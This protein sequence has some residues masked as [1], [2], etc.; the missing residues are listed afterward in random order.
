MALGSREAAEA[1]EGVLYHQYPH[2]GIPDFGCLDSQL[3]N[4]FRRAEAVV[5]AARQL[6]RRGFA[7]DVSVVHS[8]WGEALHLQKVW[9]DCRWIAYPEIYGS[10]ACLGYGFCRPL[11]QLSPQ[12]AQRIDRQ[13][14]LATAALTTYEAAVVPTQFQRGTFPPRLQP[15]LR[16]IHEGVALEKIPTGPAQPLT[17][18]DG[19]VLRRKTPLVTYTSRALEPLRGAD[20]F[21]KALPPLLHAHPT[22]QVVLVG[23][24]GSAYGSEA[25]GQEDAMAMRLQ[26]LLASPL[27][28]RIHWVERLPH[29]DLLALFRLSRAHTYLTYPYALSW[30]LLEAMACGAPV[31]GSRSAPVEEVIEERRNGLLVPFGDP[32]SLAAALLDLLLQPTKAEQMGAAARRTAEERFSLS[33]SVQAYEALFAQLLD[34]RTTGPGGPASVPPPPASPPGG[35][36]ATT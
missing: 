15:L 28:S 26:Q 36:A 1:M 30:S 32:G 9:P 13:N 10:P 27:G 24:L 31:V 19:T 23:A 7:P 22:V 18:P 34:R 6:Q 5:A 20:I 35:A 8:A 11:E 17:L 21:L 25:P 12:E 2:P 3:E 33:Q 14:L 16:V 4:S 29:P